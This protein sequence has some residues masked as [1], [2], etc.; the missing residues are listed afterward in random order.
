MSVPPRAAFH[1][2]ASKGRSAR[3]IVGSE[4]VVLDREISHRLA[5][6]I[7]IGNLAPLAGIESAGSTEL[8]A[9]SSLV[10]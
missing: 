2:A 6:S 9:F 1:A 3:Q 5:G 8:R 10:P 4:T 7:P